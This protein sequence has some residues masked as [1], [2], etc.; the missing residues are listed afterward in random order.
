MIVGC[1]IAAIITRQYRRREVGR[2]AKVARIRT[3]I[4]RKIRMLGR[5]IQRKSWSITIHASGIWDDSCGSI[6]K[7]RP[8]DS[9]RNCRRQDVNEQAQSGRYT[10]LSTTD[11]YEL[12]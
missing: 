12:L 3:A 5:L 2:L 7:V 8:D 1:R 4:N 9:S 11:I 10:A 6:C